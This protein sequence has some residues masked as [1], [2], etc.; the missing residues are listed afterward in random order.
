MPP[1]ISSQFRTD[2]DDDQV[3]NRRK[4]KENV[5]TE[6]DRENRDNVG[7][8]KKGILDKVMSTCFNLCRSRQ[9]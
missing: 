8:K 5:A 4:L 1:F 2:D 6:R 3:E 7:T 9:F